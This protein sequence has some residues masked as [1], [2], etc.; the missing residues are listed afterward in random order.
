MTLEGSKIA[1]DKIIQKARVHFYKPIQ[2][3]EILHR[4]RVNQDI[5]IAEFPAS[6]NRDF[7]EFYEGRNYNLLTDDNWI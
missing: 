1:L 5:D 6:D 4:D 7:T 3:A 2:I